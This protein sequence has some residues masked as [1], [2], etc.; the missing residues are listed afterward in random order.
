M[1]RVAWECCCV[2]A[3]V[4]VLVRIA[5]VRTRHAATA[6]GLLMMLTLSVQGEGDQAPNP[7]APRFEVV[8][9]SVVGCGDEKAFWMF[10]RASDS[11]C[12]SAQP[13]SVCSPHTGHAVSVRVTS[14]LRQYSIRAM[15]PMVW[16]QA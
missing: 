3:C 10:S 4:S 6:D 16:S 1:P 9:L 13:G 14:H 15:C 5:I 11:A 2:L 8:L 7:R 12:T